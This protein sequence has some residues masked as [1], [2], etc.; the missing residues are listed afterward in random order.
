[1]VADV[2]QTDWGDHFTLYKNTQSSCT[3][4]TK[5]MLY[6]NHTPIKNRAGKS[7]SVRR[8]CNKWLLGECIL[9]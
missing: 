4:E 3:S 1:M 9:C 8:L 2:N 6:V 5:V 7:A